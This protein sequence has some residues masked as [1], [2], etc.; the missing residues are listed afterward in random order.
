MFI[1]QFR[2]W[3]F[4]LIDFKFYL[5]NPISALYIL[6][7]AFIIFS[8]HIHKTE[9]D[10]STKYTTNRS[11]SSRT[12]QHALQVGINF[13]KLL[14][15]RGLK[16]ETIKLKIIWLRYF[17]GFSAFVLL[18]NW[19]RWGKYNCAEWT[20]SWILVW[21]RDIKI[22]STVLNNIYNKSFHLSIK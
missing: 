1:N 4:F 9:R 7:L 13:V 14:W 6:W 16:F 5:L 22:L 19:K 11:S 8:S 10:F 21:T 17:S 3:P 15:N 12:Y 2:Q 18:L 20:Q